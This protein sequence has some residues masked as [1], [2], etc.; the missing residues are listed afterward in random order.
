MSFPSEFLKIK[1]KQK[2]FGMN[3]GLRVHEVILTIFSHVLFFLKFKI[4]SDDFFCA[5][6]FH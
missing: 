4:L 5:E 3:N 1:E 6:G 2:A